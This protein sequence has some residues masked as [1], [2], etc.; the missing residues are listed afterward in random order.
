MFPLIFLLFTASPNYFLDSWIL[1]PSFPTYTFLH[2]G[3]HASAAVLSGHSIEDFR[4]YPSRRD[5]KLYFGYTQWSGPTSSNE[6]IGIQIAPLVFDVSLYLTSNYLLD[7]V[8]NRWVKSILMWFGMVAPLIDFS[9]N[10]L[11]KRATDTTEL[12]GKSSNADMIVTTVCSL[13]VVSGV[14]NVFFKL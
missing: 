6:R 9:V 13:M 10:T 1:V 11:S 4:P 3:M 2:E 14:I 5:G 7:K 12:R 8:E